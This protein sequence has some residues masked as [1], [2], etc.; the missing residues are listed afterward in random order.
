MSGGSAGQTDAA[1]VIPVLNEAEGIAALLDDC[2]AQIP[3]VAEVVVVDAGS[4]DGTEA[5]ARERAQSWPALKVI[6]VPGATPGA[7]R[8]AAIRAS[9]ARMIA[10]VDG[11]SRI[12]PSWLAELSAPLRSDPARLDVVAVGVAK[13]DARTPFERATGWLT[14]S[15][16]KPPGGQRPVGSDYIPGAGHGSCFTRTAWERAGSYPERLPWGEDKILFEGF[17]ATG[18]EVVPVP[19]ACIRWRPRTNFR[20]LHRQYRNYGRAD[21]MIGIDRRNELVTLGLYAAGAILAAGAVAGSE[22]AAVILAVAVP[23]YLAIFVVAAGRDLGMGRW[24][25]WV[26]AVRVVA[27]VAKIH[28]FVAGWVGRTFGRQ[29]E[30]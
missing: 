9:T 25:L 17:R 11:G 28:G 22:L 16:F 27:D 14:L 6:S 10:T 4:Q 1:I 8:N 5:I 20:Q 3:P 19:T 2:A 21:A 15:A 12:D 23:A 18:A 30:R 13:A 7:G 26:P 29:D 24:L